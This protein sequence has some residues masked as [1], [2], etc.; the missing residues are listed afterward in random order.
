MK[1]YYCL[2]ILFIKD[3]QLSF[4]LKEN[5]AARYIFSEFLEQ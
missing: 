3:S 1:I 5:V 4:F 2:Q